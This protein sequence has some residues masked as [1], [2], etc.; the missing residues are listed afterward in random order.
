MIPSIVLRVFYDIPAI[1]GTKRTPSPKKGK[2]RWN[3]VG[4]FR[5]GAG[6]VT[7]VLL[8]DGFDF[9]VESSPPGAHHH[10]SWME[11]L[12]YMTLIERAKW[13]RATAPDRE[14][15]GAEWCLLNP[16]HTEARWTE[17]Q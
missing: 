14:I 15:Y 17:T 6:V 16:A 4:T 11:T 12:H 3:Q 13:L 9:S 2:S 8:G 7:L 1:T 10:V 5:V